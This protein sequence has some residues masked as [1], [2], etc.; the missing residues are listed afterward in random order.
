MMMLLGGTCFFFLTSGCPVL[1]DCRHFN[2]WKSSQAILY[3]S[4]KLPRNFS[5][6]FF[7]IVFPDNQN[8][9]SAHGSDLEV[10]SR[11]IY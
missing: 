7:R 6:F 9:V 5:F 8:F 1:L 10:P 3:T 2:T 4:T 11:R